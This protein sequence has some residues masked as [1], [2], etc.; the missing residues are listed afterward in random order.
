MPPT[1]VEDPSDKEA[2]EQAQAV[3]CELQKKAF[4]F[5]VPIAVEEEKEQED[6]EVDEIVELE[7]QN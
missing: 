7:I 2:Q 4:N 3:T 5:Q 6:D 1:G